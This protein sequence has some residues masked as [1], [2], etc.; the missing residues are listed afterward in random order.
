MKAQISRRRLYSVQMTG[1]GQHRQDRRFTQFV[2]NPCLVV[3]T[4]RVNF[5]GGVKLSQNWQ[6]PL[7]LAD[8]YVQMTGSLS[9]TRVHPSCNVYP[10][11]TEL[12]VPRD[13]QGCRL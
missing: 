13:W 8:G 10:F 9:S 5:I 4:G 7:T 6:M 2:Q 1:Q 3:M 12:G 11:Q